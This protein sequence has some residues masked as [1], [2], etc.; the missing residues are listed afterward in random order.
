MQEGVK[1]DDACDARIVYF[2]PPPEDTVDPGGVRAGVAVLD[3]G[4]FAGQRVEFES[5][6]CAVF[7]HS[8]ARADLSQ[9][10]TAGETPHKAHF[11]IHFKQFRKAELDC[12]I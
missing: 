9:I 11:F 1:S 8:L 5:R 4:P 7:G 10:F 6:Q 2:R 12:R 3:N